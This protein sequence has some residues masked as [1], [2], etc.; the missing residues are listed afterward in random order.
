MSSGVWADQ[1]YALIKE[2][3]VLTRLDVLQ[4][5]PAVSMAQNMALAHNVILRSIN[6]SYNQC[7]S[8]R[9]GTPEATDF[10][11]F[12]QCIFEFVK[13]HHDVEEEHLFPDIAKLT[14]VAGI[15]EG[16]VQEH[17]DFEAG[18]EKFRQYVY[19]TPADRYDGTKLQAILDEF[20]KP[21]EKHMHNEIS[22]LLNLKDYDAVK[23]KEVIASLGK[24]FAKA[25]DLFR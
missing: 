20:G 18:M 2:T 23:L 22:T 7:L 9:P 15:M 11:I 8:V 4:D 16:N 17:R 25:G 5:H 1:P 19:D 10:L 24:Q 13:T 12:N 6:A 14:G 3:G 21:L